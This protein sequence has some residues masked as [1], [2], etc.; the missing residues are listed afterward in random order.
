MMEGFRRLSH[1]G[2]QLLCLRYWNEQWDRFIEAIKV[3]RES[4]VS[5]TLNVSDR[6]TSKRDVGGPRGCAKESV[7]VSCRHGNPD[8]IQKQDSKAVWIAKDAAQSD[9]QS[10]G[11]LYCALHCGPEQRT[12][13][14]IEVA[15]L[16]LGLCC[17]FTTSPWTSSLPHAGTC[18]LFELCA[19]I[20][21]GLYLGLLVLSSLSWI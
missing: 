16:S 21:M 20:A 15:A 6:L 19:V 5:A 18:S 2:V 14:Q 13:N 8:S 1:A 11:A 4:F 17:P 3:K 7:A 12:A 10:Y 9:S